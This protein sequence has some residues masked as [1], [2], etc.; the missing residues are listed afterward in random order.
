MTPAEMQI[1]EARI[2]LY[3]SLERLAD[4]ATHEQLSR[5]REPLQT[6]LRT[7]LMRF[8]EFRRALDAA[9]LPPDAR[10]RVRPQDRAAAAR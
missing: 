5:V 4:V 7:S 8:R 3:V 9:R 1:A 6:Y 2:D 10:P